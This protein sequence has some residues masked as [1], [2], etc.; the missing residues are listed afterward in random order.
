MNQHRQTERD[1]AP[2]FAGFAATPDGHPLQPRWFAAEAVG[3]GQFLHTFDGPL[4]R[5]IGGQILIQFLEADV[6]RALPQQRVQEI[7]VGNRLRDW[8]L[9]WGSSRS[10]SAVAL[11]LGRVLRLR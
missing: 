10:G 2:R 4:A 7:E 3:G 6:L 11:M 9:S 5:D 8:K 1:H